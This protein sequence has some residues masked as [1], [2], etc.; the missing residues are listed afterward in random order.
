MYLRYLPLVLLAATAS[1]ASALQLGDV[2]LFHPMASTTTYLIDDAG[3]VAHSWP[4]TATPGLSVYLL[5]NLNLLRTYR[6]GAGLAGG[7][8]GGVQEL[9]WDG[10]VVWDFTYANLP[11]H[12]QHHDVEMLPN[13]NVLMIAWEGISA[14]SAA[15]AG[16]NPALIQGPTF[17]PDH[18]IEVQKT[19]PTS[20]AIVWSWHVM[21]H[22]IQDFDPARPDFGVVADHPELIDLNYPLQPASDWNHI[23]SVD[24]NAE[25]DQILLSSHNQN[26]V[27]VIDHSTTTLEAAGHTGGNSGKGGDLLYRWGNPEAYGAGT[28]FDKQLFGQHDAQWVEDGYP[29]EG[30]IICFNNGFMRPAGAYSSVDEIVPPVDSMGNYALMPGSAFAP[31]APVWIWTDAVPTNFYSSNISGCERIKNGNTLA[32]HGQMGLILEVDSALNTVWS[33]QN[34]IPNPNNGRMFRARRYTLCSDPV[35]FCQTAANSNGSGALMGWSGSAS[36]GSND[37]VLNATGASSSQ[38]GI[39][40]LGSNQIQAPFGNGFRCAGGNVLRLPPIVSDPIGFATLA[41]D[42]TGPQSVNVVQSGETWNFQFWFR[43]PFGGGPGFNLSDGMAV[44]FCD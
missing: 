9:E 37:L 27:W 12:L 30:N 15:A 21:D 8:G 41:L 32:I 24:Y 5:D 1:P 19:G 29:G 33:H 40:F 17:Y 36:L 31:A 22:V 25:F 3:S 11:G 26:E 42:Y 44:T 38:P 18:I 16:R 4:G 13:G 14:A 6:I 39:F 23:N 7:S 34:T 43:D 28:L 10:T 20:G 2:T 35:S